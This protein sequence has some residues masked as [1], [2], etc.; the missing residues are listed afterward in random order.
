MSEPTWAT[1]W[2]QN[3]VSR[4]QTKVSAVSTPLNTRLFQDNPRKAAVKRK[5][6]A[7]GVRGRDKSVKKRKQKARAVTAAAAEIASFETE[8]PAMAELLK[9]QKVRS[10]EN[11]RP[12]GVF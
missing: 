5:R 1:P 6:E 4:C 10:R 3:T 9:Q 8:D 7:A 11:M 12:R 2:T